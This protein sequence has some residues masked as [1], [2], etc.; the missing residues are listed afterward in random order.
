MLY[1]NFVARGSGEKGV[2]GWEDC[3]RSEEW[4]VKNEGDTIRFMDVGVTEKDDAK[5]RFDSKRELRDCGVKSW[6][7]KKMYCCVVR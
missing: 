2:L 6:K 4:Y 7:E 5:S 3:F 1:I